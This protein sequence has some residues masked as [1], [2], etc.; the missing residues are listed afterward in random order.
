M[1]MV[2]M[3]FLGA[4]GARPVASFCALLLLLLRSWS[5]VW[6]RVSRGCRGH[7]TRTGSTKTGEQRSGFKLRASGTHPGVRD[8]AADVGLSA[9]ATG[10]PNQDV[11][12]CG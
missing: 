5:V 12:R 11:A 9:I 1:D 7:G 2:A 6:W 8:D 4:A 3:L 10:T